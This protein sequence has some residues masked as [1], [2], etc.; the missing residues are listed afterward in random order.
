MLGELQPTRQ[1]IVC[2][3]PL[4]KVGDAHVQDPSHEGLAEAAFEGQDI[5]NPDVRALLLRMGLIESGGGE[6]PRLRRVEVN[7]RTG[8]DLETPHP[9]AQIVRG[10]RIIP[11]CGGKHPQAG[12]EVS[13]VSVPAQ[14]YGLDVNIGQARARFTNEAE[15]RRFQYCVL[16]ARV[17]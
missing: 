17:N 5:P 2:H 7:R 1:V 10:V 16:K 13:S 15:N 11:S 14:V 3:L 4:R 9:Q 6:V 12:N 8:K